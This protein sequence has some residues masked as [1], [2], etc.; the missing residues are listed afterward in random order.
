MKKKV[1]IQTIS[2]GIIC[3]M[4]CMLCSVIDK[5]FEPIQVGLAC[6]ASGVIGFWF[7]GNVRK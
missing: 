5:H 6:T 3:F 1:F 4:V 7:G 2:Y